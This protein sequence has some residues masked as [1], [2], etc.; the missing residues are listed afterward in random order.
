MLINARIGCVPYLNARPLLDGLIH[1]ITELVPAKLIEAFRRGE[2]DAALISS[3]D[4]ISMTHPEVVDGVAIASRGEVFSVFLAYKGELESLESVILDPSS[5]TSNA[6]LQIILTEF[7][8]VQ[9]QY[10]QLTDID[11][12]YL[13][14]NF[15]RLFIGDPAIALRKQSVDPEIR[16]LDL[17]EEW[18]RFTELPFIYALWLLK[19]DF[20]EKKLLSDSLREAKVRGLSNSENIAQKTSDPEFTRRYLNEW[21]R[22]ELGEEEKRGLT[23]FTELLIKHKIADNSLEN[24]T[25]I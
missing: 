20:T 23:R 22:Y 10:V 18:F 12:H 17:G 4:V 5:H 25:Y 3:I 16:F 14:T 24:I 9:P 8:G 11:S 2:F 19:N 21:I 1:P 15:P 13:P 6:L 7:Y